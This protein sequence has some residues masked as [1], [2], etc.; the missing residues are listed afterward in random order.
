VSTDPTNTGTLLWIIA[1][2]TT[3]SC[4]VWRFNQG[5]A[6]GRQR[7]DAKVQVR[8]RRPRAACVPRVGRRRKRFSRGTR[9]QNPGRVG[10]RSGL[11]GANAAHDPAPERPSQVRGSRAP[12]PRRSAPHADSAFAPA[13][14]LS[15]D[16]APWPPGGRWRPASGTLDNRLGGQD[17]GRAAPRQENGA[18]SVTKSREGEQATRQEGHVH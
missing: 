18:V 16:W 7:V 15:C 14:R 13:R 2:S 4:K 3:F 17:Q 12:R 10:I 11:G 8:V 1:M 5:T 9:S 6:H